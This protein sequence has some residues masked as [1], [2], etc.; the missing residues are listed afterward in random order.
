MLKIDH[1]QIYI[2]SY[3]LSR[4]SKTAVNS[5]WSW[6]NNIWQHFS[7]EKEVIFSQANLGYPLTKVKKN[8]IQIKLMV[9][10]SFA[11]WM[12]AKAF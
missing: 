9:P 7:H 11:V 6:A 8:R 2:Y 12:I 5:I 3:Q 10:S 4:E 1:L